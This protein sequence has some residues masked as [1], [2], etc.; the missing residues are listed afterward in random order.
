MK[1]IFTLLLIIFLI[2][3]CAKKE[4]KKILSNGSEKINSA[5]VEGDWIVLSFPAEPEK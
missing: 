3:S 5:A 2:Y 4:E 1:K